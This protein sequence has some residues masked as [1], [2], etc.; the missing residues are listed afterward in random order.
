MLTGKHEPSSPQEEAEQQPH[1][2]I[3]C[4]YRF[5]HIPFYSR[6]ECWWLLATS[7]HLGAD[8][9]GS[10]MGWPTST[11]L[12][13][14]ASGSCGWIRGTTYPEGGRL[15]QALT[16]L[17]SSPEPGTVY[18]NNPVS[19]PYK[20]KMVP[21]KILRASIPFHLHQNRSP[22]GQ[23]SWLTQSSKRTQRRKR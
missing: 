11:G 6:E 17:F 23:E 1:V 3:L 20:R 14:S 22:E 10:S 19:S 8:L 15:A 18:P 5:Q 12:T 4:V 16:P 2:A 7:P 13:T 21:P 9:Q